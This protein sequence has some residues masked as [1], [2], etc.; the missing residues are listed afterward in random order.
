MPAERIRKYLKNYEVAE[1]V[2]RLA[3]TLPMRV[4]VPSSYLIGRVAE[5]L[6]ASGC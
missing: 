3:A 1:L 2:M 4:Q 6:I 5:W